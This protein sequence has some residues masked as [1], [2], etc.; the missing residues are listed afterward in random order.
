MGEREDNI[1]VIMEIFENKLGD[2]FFIHGMEQIEHHIPE[3]KEL[4]A[5]GDEHL[6][7]E[8]AD[9]YLWSRILLR[10]EDVSEE[11]IDRRSKHFLEK[12][13]NMFLESDGQ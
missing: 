6:K 13:Q 5:K 1:E 12:I 4:K 9:L 8:L 11:T 3:L 10:L 2:D 7:G